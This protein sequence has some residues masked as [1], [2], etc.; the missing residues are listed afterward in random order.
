MISLDFEIH[1]GV[2]DLVSTRGPYEANLLGVRQAVPAMLRQFEEFEIAATWATVGFL[3]ARSRDELQAFS[4]AIRPSYH[5][6]ALSAYAEPL[7]EGEDDDP[8]HYAPT[9]IQ[10]IRNTPRQE[11]GTHT[12]SHYYCFEPG[13]DRDAFRAD[14]ASATAIAAQHGVAMRS[15]VF[16]RNQHNPE[17]DDVLQAAGISCLRGNPDAWMYR[18]RGSMASRG[19]RLLDAYV[20]VSG[21]LT[22]AW[23]ALLQPNGLCNVPASLFLRPYSPARRALDG[24]RLRRIAALI[25]R[26]ATSREIVHLWWHPHNFGAHVE[27]NIAFLRAVLEIFARYRESHGLQSLSM[28]DVAA[29]CRTR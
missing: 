12:F 27:Q 20:P 24:V 5:N 7:G 6:T 13:Q 11:I 26:A 16:P 3:F 17:Y 15:I 21:P 23:D 19:A 22:S 25:R 4:P 14:L 2:R 8:F 29:R 1:W 10:A 28:S 18:R 9:L